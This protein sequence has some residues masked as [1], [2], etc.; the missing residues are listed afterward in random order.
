MGTNPDGKLCIY[1]NVADAVVLFITKDVNMSILSTNFEIALSWKISAMLAGPLLK[2]D[3]GGAVTQ[4]CEKIASYWIEQAKTID[5]KQHRGK[6]IFIPK[7]I[8][9]R[10]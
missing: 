3:S 10:F 4:S 6:R 2:G 8:A 5:H 1:T 9:A 7:A